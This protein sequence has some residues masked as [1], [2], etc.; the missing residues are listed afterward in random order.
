MLW[1]SAT[2]IKFADVLSAAFTL[3]SVWTPRN[4]HHNWVWGMEAQQPSCKCLC[5]SAIQQGN[6][7]S[8]TLSLIGTLDTLIFKG[9]TIFQSFIWDLGAR[10]IQAHGM[11]SVNITLPFALQFSLLLLWGYFFLRKKKKKNITCQILSE[12]KEA[13]AVLFA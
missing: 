7:T 6:L 2:S 9:R 4:T 11:V 13:G 5:P 10:I 8:E 12:E 1:C 3:F